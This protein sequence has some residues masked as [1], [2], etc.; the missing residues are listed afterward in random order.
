MGTREEGGR[1]LSTKKSKGALEVK[2]GVNLV[3]R[4]TTTNGTSF[5]KSEIF[6]TTVILPRP[7]KNAVRQG[8]YEKV[9]TRCLQS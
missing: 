4:K 8:C 9:T 1:R 3:T 2:E 6:A 7:M 5:S